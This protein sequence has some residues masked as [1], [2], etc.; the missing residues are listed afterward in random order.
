MIHDLGFTVTSSVPV[1][2][3]LAKLN[4]DDMTCLSCVRKIEE[5]LS[6]MAGVRLAVVSLDNNSAYI[7]YDPAKISVEKLC[8]I[9]VDVGFKA[10][11]YN[12]M[13]E[14]TRIRVEG[15]T[16]NSCV[17]SIESHIG[18][19]PGIRKIVVSLKRKMAIVN[20]DSSITTPTAIAE[21]I[22]SMGFDAV[23]FNDFKLAAMQKSLEESICTDGKDAD[24]CVGV[25]CDSSSNEA[26]CS[27]RDTVEVLIAVNGMTC[28][29][30]VRSVEA[31]VMG[32]SNVAAVRVSLAD[33]NARVTI[34]GKVTT[35]E[36]IAA[37]ISDIGFDASLVK[38]ADSN[39]SVMISIRGMHCNS[40]TKAIE[41]HLRN[42]SGVKSVKISLLAETA[43]IVFNPSAVE[44]EQLI[45]AIESAGDFNASIVGK[46]LDMN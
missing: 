44:V 29:S 45:G 40:C 28:D 23:V 22:D 35:A 16:C 18:G 3:K 14:E 20:Y 32:L 1:S 36:M 17:H 39:K 21:E 11:P 43:D 6:P 30:C 4:I 42:L 15:M 37:A 12:T 27:S 31:C 7:V 8:L 19:L 38:V 25:S 24:K 41:G 46:C 26:T 2:C 33:S 9:V 34:A 13:G 5:A 10:S